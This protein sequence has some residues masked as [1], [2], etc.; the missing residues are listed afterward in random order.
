M[1]EAR[2]IFL[3]MGLT[4]RVLNNEKKKNPKQPKKPNTNYKK[5]STSFCK[6]K[7][8]NAFFFSFFFLN[9]SVKSAQRLRTPALLKTIFARGGETRLEL[10]NPRTVKYDVVLPEPL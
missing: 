8:I 4:I 7:M 9:D 2:K 1:D 3:D 10:S 5:A 6:K